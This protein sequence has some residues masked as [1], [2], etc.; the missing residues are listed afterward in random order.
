M[1]INMFL[2]Q[3]KELNEKRINK[4]N[5]IYSYF[6]YANLFYLEG[7]AKNYNIQLHKIVIKEEVKNKVLNGNYIINLLSGRNKEGSLNQGSH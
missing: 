2:F 1:N 7:I 5:N 4:K 3:Y 6:I